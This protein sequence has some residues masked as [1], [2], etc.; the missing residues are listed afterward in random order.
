MCVGAQL[1]PV[2]CGPSKLVSW[3]IAAIER[4]L[5][6]VVLILHFHTSFHF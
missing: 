6:M 1:S 4:V 5:S 3:T 2:I